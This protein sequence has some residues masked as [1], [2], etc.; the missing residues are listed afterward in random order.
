MA[1]FSLNDTQWLTQ[2]S[3]EPAAARRRQ[4]GRAALACALI[5]T[6]GLVVAARA[7]F[8]DEQVSPAARLAQAQVE[9]E[10][11]STELE[12]ANTELEMERATRAELQ[13]HADELGERVAK[14][15]QQ[16]EFLSSRGTMAGNR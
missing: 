14:L 6:A 1:R 7:G 13:R 8:L 5:A 2:A 15:T 10:R 9:V 12:R 16:I 4:F 11:L 3:F